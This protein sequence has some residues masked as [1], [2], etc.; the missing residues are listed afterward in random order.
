MKNKTIVFSKPVA[1][2]SKVEKDKLFTTIYNRYQKPVLH[3]IIEKIK[4]LDVAEEVCSKTFA[5]VY[6]NLDK[7]NDSKAV[8]STW[9]YKVALNT[10]I[11]EIRSNSVDNKV[12]KVSDF[13]DQEGNET[14]QLIADD[15]SQQTMEADELKATIIASFRKLKPNYRRI[16]VLYFMNQKDYNEV[17]EICNVPL[18]TVKGMISRC[19]EMLQAELK[20]VVAF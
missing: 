17:A 14:F 2:M 1:E 13:V 9:I 16:A 19:R 5:K 7:F 20:G 11:D 6:N 12:L 18:G 8:L 3:Y 4:N 15:D 10:L